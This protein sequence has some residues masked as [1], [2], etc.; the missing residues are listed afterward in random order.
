MRRITTESRVRSLREPLD[1]LRDCS[2][3]VE[4]RHDAAVS[5]RHWAA[6]LSLLC[7][8]PPT[9]EERL[10]ALMDRLPCREAEVG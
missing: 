7:L 9:D 3:L 2:R 6:W 8:T 4:P 1:D 10:L 5:R